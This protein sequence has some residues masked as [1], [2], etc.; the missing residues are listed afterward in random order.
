MAE[1]ECL[2]D[3]VVMSH[4]HDR[5]VVILKERGGSRRFPIIIG[6]FEVYAIHRFVHNEPPQRPLTH[7][8]LGSV[9]SELGATLERV[10]VNDLR[11]NT[12]FA[13]IFL[14]RDGQVYEL[15]SR[16]SDAMALAVQKGAPIF[17]AE[18]VLEAASRDFGKSE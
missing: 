5:Q 14:K 11:D 17:V 7:E 16:P 15:D 6:P 13:R 1:V 2:M 18:H 4:Q 8:L 9:L 12:F 10:V 3:Q